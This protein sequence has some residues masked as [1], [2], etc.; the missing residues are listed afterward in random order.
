MPARAADFKPNGPRDRS[1]AKFERASRLACLEQDA[2]SFHSVKHAPHASSPEVGWLPDFV[3]VG[4]QFESGL[5]FFADERGRITRFSREP[6]DL[7]AA[8]R[9]S[10]QAALPGLVNGHSQVLHRLLRGRNA[11][12]NAAAGDREELEAFA[13]VTARLTPEDIYDVARMAFLEMMLSGITCV[14]EFLTLH[15][16]P[17]GSSWPEANLTSHAVLRAARDV[18]IRISLFKVARTRNDDRDTAA[19]SVGRVLTES[20]ESFIEEME[21]LKQ[22]VAREHPGDD[23]WLGVGVDGMTGVSSEQLTAIAGY[24]HAQRLRLHLPVSTCADD[25]EACRT[26]HGQAPIE[27]LQSRHLLDKRFV[28]IHAGHLSEQEIRLLGEA[29]AIVCVCPFSERYRGN[30]SASV[31]ELLRAGADICLGTDR[32]QRINLLEDA[33]LFEYTLRHESS[34]HG[35]PATATAVA[36]M[37]AATVVGA[38]SLG[39]PSGALETG[40]PA[41]FFTVN[42]FD[43]SIAGCDPDSLLRNVVQSLERRAIREVWVGGLRRVASAHHPQQGRIIG[44]FVD[45]R[46]R[47]NEN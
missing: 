25:N 13:R 23:T 12:G 5:A 21:A 42:L 6:A 7:E 16:R 10:G 41:D 9:L 34:S 26:L 20:A 44:R 18:G 36:A 32:Q 27:F 24:A 22:Y 11:P 28:A 17:D 37:H 46:K 31:S 47:L 8:R 19:P 30:S 43:P 29:R 45:L 1:P 35:A 39:A 38:R 4:D 14:G 15:R 3:Y 2:S 33:R 40:R